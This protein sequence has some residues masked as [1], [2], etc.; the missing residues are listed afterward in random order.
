MKN[1]FTKCMVFS[2]LIS[3]SLMV[4]G[5]FASAEGQKATICHV[6][7][8][9][10]SNAHEIVVSQKALESHL[11]NHPGDQLGPCQ[12]GCASNNDCDDANLCTTDVC[13][14]DGSL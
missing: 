8:D 5:G 3:L 1:L 13:N 12:T 10:P 7:P 6:P 2:L 9:D 4:T 11:R 14:P